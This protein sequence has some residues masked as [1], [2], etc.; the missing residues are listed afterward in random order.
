LKTKYFSSLLPELATRATRATVSRLGFSNPALRAYLT[1]FFSASYGEKGCFLGDPV[2]EATFGWEEADATMESLAPSLLMPSLVNA[3]DRPEGGKSDDYRFPRAARPYRHQLE[4]W[5]ILGAEKPQSVVVTSGTGSGKTECFM[6]PILNQLARAHEE[7]GAKLVGVEALFLYPLNALIQ[8]QRE[9]LHAWTSS[10]GDGVRFCLYNGLT[11]QTEKQF[12]R[13]ATPNQVVDR[14]ILR[15]APPPILVTNATMLEYMLV[16]AQDASILD[17]SK[18]KLKWIVLDEAHTYIGSQAA[19]LALLLRRV[20]HAFDVK[21]EQVRFVAT[22]ATLGGKEAEGALKDFLAR[23]SGLPLDHVHV[24]SGSR[25]IPKLEQGNSRYESASLEELEALPGDS[26]DRYQ[27]LCAN[28]T[29]RGLREMLVPPA[30]RATNLSAIKEALF[31]AEFKRKPDANELALRWLDL[32][33]GVT[34]KSATG[35]IPFLPLRLHAFHNVLKGLWACADSDCRC[36]RGT[37]LDAAEWRYGMVYGEPR[38]HCDCGSPV[39]ELRSCNDCNTTFLWARRVLNKAD[40]LY[41]LVQGAEDT[42]DEFALDV[43]LA[44]DD[45]EASDSVTDDSPVLIANGY[46]VGTAEV[47]VARESLV[48]HPVDIEDVVRLRGRDETH[49]G[50]DGQMAMVCPECGGQHGNGTH[51]FRPAILG[52]PFLLGVIIPTLLEFCPDIDSKD[53][54]P[55]E[56]PLRGR[57]MISFTDSRQGTARIAAKLQ[58]DSERNRVRG[59]IF[60]KVMTAGTAS[61]NV[62][63]ASEN[64]DIANLREALKLSGPNPFIQEML[65]AKLAKAESAATIKPVQFAE[66]AEWLSAAASDVKDWMHDYY[67]SLDPTEF[68]SNSGRERLARILL[69]REFARRPKR[70]NSLETMGLVRTTYPKL[71]VVT[72]VPDF[73][74]GI[75]AFSLTDWKDFLKIALDFHV[76][77]NTFIDLP[78]SWRKW[79]GNRLSAKQL[80]PPDSKE[81]QT[82]RLKRWPQC[83]PAG[84]QSRLVRLLA[85]VCKIDA[86][87]SYGKEI[88]DSILRSAWDQLSSVGLL[89]PGGVG[90]YLMLNDVAL[91]P[92]EKAWVC[93]VT[94][95]VLDVTFRGVTP[96]LPE[97]VVSSTVADC[98]PVTIPRCDLVLRDFPSEDDRIGAIRDWLNRDD[99]VVRLRSEGLWSDLND[100]ILEG[101]TYFRAAEHSAQQPGARLAEYESL[102]KTGKINL[103]SCST[104]MEMGV[105]IGGISVV[106]MN[107]VPPHPANYLQRAGR[108]GRRSE[109]RSAALSLCK[110]NPH[111][112]NV[113]SDTLW[114]FHTE[115]P[116]PAVLLSSPILIQRHINSMLLAAFL[117]KEL[118]GSGSAEKLNLEW[119]MLPRDSARLQRFCAW[120]S[121]FDPVKDVQL[122]QGLRSL[123]RHTP[124]EGTASLDRLAHEAARM[125]GDH[126]FAWYAEFDAIETELGRFTL[127][128]VKNSPAYKALT[129]QKKRLTGEYLLRE[130]ATEGFLPGYGFPTNISSF[131]TLTCDEMERSKAQRSHTENEPGRIDNRMRFRDL[132]S[133]DTVTALREYAPGSEVV[134]DG[135]VY[136]SGGITLNWHAPASVTDI[137][138][139]QNIRDAWR[140]RNCGSSGTSVRAKPVAECPDCGSALIADPDSR[141][142]YLEP[143]GFSVDL[144]E[145]PHNDVS[146][147]SFVPVASP[148]VNAQ[149]EWLPLLNP[150]LGLYR[151]STD[152]M[153]FNYSAGAKGHGYALCLG[154]GRTEPMDAADQMPAVFVDSK[155]GKHREHNRLRGAQG[156]DSRTCEGSYNSFAIMQSL[157]LGHEAHT[158]VLELLL[159]GLDGLPLKDRQVAYTLAVAIRNAV[160]SLLGI[161][162]SELGCDTKPVKIAG[163]VVSQAI[164]IFDKNASGYCSSVSDK[165]QLLLQMTKKE[166]ECSDNCHDACQHCL[167]DFETR[168][169]SDDLNRHAALAFASERWLAEFA[170]PKERAYFGESRSS[171]EHQSL[172][173]ALTRELTAPGAKSLRIYLAG[174]AANWDI[175]ASPLR[176]WLTRWV[177]SGADLQIVMPE[178]TVPLL[179]QPD[180]S[181]LHALC[182]LDGVSVWTGVTPACNG[183]ATVVAEVIGPQGSIAWA[184]RSIAMVTPAGEWGEPDGDVIVRGQLSAS[185]N[186]DRQLNFEAIPLAP[187]SERTH[188]LELKSELDG[189]VIGFGGRLLAAIEAELGAE[190]FPKDTDIVEVTYHDRYLNS[191][192]PVSLLLEFISA[193]K[194]TYEDRWGIQ[195]FSLM[196]SPFNDERRTNMPPSK[197]WHNWPQPEDRDHAIEAAFEFSG[198]NVEVV[199]LSKQDAIHAR[200]LDFKLDGGEVVQIWF[201]QGCSYWQSPRAYPSVGRSWFPFDR[202]PESQG[203]AIARADVRVEGQAFPTYV[204]IRR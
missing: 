107:N 117:R 30:E 57:R 70:V 114:A 204:F 5:R 68:A 122:A 178:K 151:S 59:L 161:E 125:A 58:Q 6:V 160:A 185:G 195:K 121:C 20:L 78:D 177:V 135:L 1:E 129:I 154:C 192:L 159:F 180:K 12:H 165:L 162:S 72:R 67:A 200:R 119:W 26:D 11:P 85:Y 95:R 41:R 60:R 4:S 106:A 50:D 82:N 80:L 104:T 17:A 188:R 52:A 31:G 139:I 53:A 35:R 197:I 9:R 120:A 66:I 203:E 63:A 96:Y 105:D 90:R 69:M 137:T 25:K 19:E 194:T 93:P 16:R 64:Q 184:T 181:C 109:T 45:S 75:P 173:E 92:I 55:L 74:P 132:P 13:N 15:A 61:A 189:Q 166:L 186:L 103:L 36:K 145:S 56:R 71:D 40:G 10:F 83:N 84:R 136:R 113:F 115:L 187:M 142:V 169:R 89:Q 127:S 51:M 198:I 170:L 3:L 131:E 148:W 174:D 133:R 111:D 88:I 163:G 29:A 23:L 146:T 116:A 97:K 130:L 124:H 34:K 7:R 28:R 171:A 46:Q 141:F 138:E 77:E 168:F 99:S 167:L 101:G 123:L 37:A 14:E 158:D 49:V 110:N 176:R 201:D 183:D 42:R 172:P 102:F 18:G 118:A 153:V 39:Y 190:L 112:Q 76:R 86:G 202:D 140:C 98:R 94:R 79:G 179:S 155:T 182:A 44:D 54:K 21:P 164:V 81:A 2:F 193:V 91:A 27:S 128:D 199:S 157:R 73:P 191:P 22:S 156:G 33:T 8:S 43:E 100:R 152:G 62:A 48:M 87:S 144:Y 126:A 65:D 147:Q 143:A 150:A 24:V 47:V 196:L 149:G 32:L 175:S 134:I 108:A 38:L